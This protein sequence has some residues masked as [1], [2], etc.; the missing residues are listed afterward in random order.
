M[1]LNLSYRQRIE[2]Y[3]NKN[4]TL[5]TR[6]KW[7]LRVLTASNQASLWVHWLLWLQAHP[8]SSLYSR[9]LSSCRAYRISSTSSRT[10]RETSIATLIGD[11]DDVANAT[12]IATWNDDGMASDFGSY[13]HA[14]YE[15]K[16]WWQNKRF[17]KL[18]S[19]KNFSCPR[20][21]L[22]RTWRHG[23]TL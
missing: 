21:C 2:R 5:V 17:L 16:R 9:F 4:P 19:A 1:W 15:E 6:K 12:E 20:I 7:F 23:V 14:F 18:W 22:K 11:A 8:Y 13:V 3:W 10:F